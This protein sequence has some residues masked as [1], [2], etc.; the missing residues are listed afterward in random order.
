MAIYV[1]GSF[2]FPRFDPSFPH[3]F[4]FL[5]IS[6]ACSLPVPAGGM[7]IAAIGPMI[8]FYGPSFVLLIGGDLHCGAG[9]RLPRH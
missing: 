4:E 3:R 6:L 8:G 1:V 7:T 5:T 2:G 9:E